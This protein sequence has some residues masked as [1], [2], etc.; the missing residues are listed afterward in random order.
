MFVLD[1]LKNDLKDFKNS[2]SSMDSIFFIIISNEDG[3]A[4]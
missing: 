1:K 2:S 4:Y 3:V